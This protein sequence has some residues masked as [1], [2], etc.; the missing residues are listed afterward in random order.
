MLLETFP[1]M[2][3][4]TELRLS[5][6]LAIISFVD[7]CFVPGGT[8]VDSTLLISLIHFRIVS[9]LKFPIDCLWWVLPPQSLCRLIH[10]R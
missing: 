7:G 9:A 10:C 6:K 1:V 5:P 4:D 3:L 2:H 8:G